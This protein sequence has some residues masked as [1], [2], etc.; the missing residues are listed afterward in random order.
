MRTNRTPEEYTK[1]LE[2]LMLE[3]E[4]TF[5]RCEECKEVDHV[6]QISDA[7]LEANGKR[8][9]MACENHE[10]REI[11]MWD[12]ELECETYHYEHR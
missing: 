4:D 9:C 6:N 12:D 10:M 8:V 7:V 5:F 3:D 2:S 1:H 11:A